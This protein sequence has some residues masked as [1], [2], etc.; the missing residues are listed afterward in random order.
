MESMIR[1]GKTA[2]SKSDETE[3][4]FEHFVCRA[5]NKLRVTVNVRHEISI[6]L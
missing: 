3:R 1:T 2:F 6:G 4:Y 5:L